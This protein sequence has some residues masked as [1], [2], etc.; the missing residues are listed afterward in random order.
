M[1]EFDWRLVEIGFRVLFIAVTF[2][3]LLIVALG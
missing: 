1:A 2:V 3:L